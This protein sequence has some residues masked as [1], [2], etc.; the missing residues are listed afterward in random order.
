[1]CLLL[2]GCQILAPYSEAQEAGA[3]SA[4]TDALA[5]LEGSQEERLRGLEQ[6]TNTICPAELRD[7]GRRTVLRL[8]RDH[9]FEDESFIAS[10]VKLLSVWNVNVGSVLVRSV[11]SGDEALSF[12]IARALRSQGSGSSKDL[13]LELAEIV[14]SNRA[15]GPRMGAVETLGILR[16]RNEGALAALRQALKDSDSRIRLR[17]VI[18]LRRTA[19]SSPET[20]GSLKS[21]LDDPSS[22]IASR[23]REGLTAL[24]ADP[25]P[26]IADSK[27]DAMNTEV[28]AALRSDSSVVD[29][30]QGE[31]A[32]ADAEGARAS[33]K[34]PEEAIQ[35]KVAALEPPAPVAE[36]AVSH[37]GT[38]GIP[39]GFS[40][41][42]NHP[43]PT[44]RAETA[45]KI[46]EL[47]V[48]DENL[49]PALSK[50]LRDSDSRVRFSAGYVMQ[51]IGVVGVAPLAEALSDQNPLVRQNAAQALHPLIAS[52]QKVFDLMEKAL[53]EDADSAVKIQAATSLLSV[54]PFH[55]PAVGVLIREL[56]AA[57][58]QLRTRM[59]ESLKSADATVLFAQFR[60]AAREED[61]ILR[62]EIAL[63]LTEIAPAARSTRKLLIELLDDEDEQ[64]KES[65]AAALRRQEVVD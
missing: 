14:G 57:S 26:S 59:L 51:K 49:L 44:V 50:A 12:A 6:L 55:K 63:T 22:T 43:D 28:T 58:A 34:R 41:G 19:D 7:E 21:V 56:P 48:F 23:A 16:T 3:P 36:N 65:A 42:L 47:K 53:K 1:M 62:R 45:M 31:K 15:M 2:G 35:T 38:Q 32:Q 11:L 40:D 20:I 37:E 18:A 24:G 33:L 61:P 27:P 60:E 17:A 9:S 5:L 4:C 54:N 8:L 52:D 39:K 25:A 13:A 30:S 46:A 29:L 64:V 10:L